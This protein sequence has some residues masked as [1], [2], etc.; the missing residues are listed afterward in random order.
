MLARTRR[1]FPTFRDVTRPACS[2][3]WTSRWTEGWGAPTRAAISVRL[4]SRSGS[5]SRSARISPCCWERRMGKSAGAGRLSTTGRIL[6]NLQ[7]VELRV[8]VA[9]IDAAPLRDGQTGARPDRP[10]RDGAFRMDL[11]A[12]PEICNPVI[13]GLADLGSQTGSQQRQTPDDAS[14]PQARISA[15]RWLV[16]RQSPTVRYCSAAPESGR[17]AVRP[18]P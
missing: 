12:G 6:F 18:R 14:R 13:A 7:T 2:A 11:A 9:S 10:I 15:V 17:S 5:P 8:Y 3:R 16:R 1:V 4:S